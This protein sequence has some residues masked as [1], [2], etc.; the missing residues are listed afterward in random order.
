MDNKVNPRSYLGKFY[1]DSLVH[2]PQ[3][4]RFILDIFGHDKVILG[5]DYPFP[6]GEEEPGRLIESLTDLP[7]STIKGVL[8]DNALEW[9]ALEAEELGLPAGLDSDRSKQNVPK[10]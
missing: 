5:S 4:L 10:R 9:L 3:A 1:V 2:D 6:L 8:T 7:E